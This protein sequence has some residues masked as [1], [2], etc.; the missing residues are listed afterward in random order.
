MNE[1]EHKRIIKRLTSPLDR[2]EWFMHPQTVN[3]Y[4]A[5]T[6]NDIVFPAA[7][8]Q[9]PFFNV[10]G[11]DAVNYGSIGAIIGHEITHGFDDEGSKYDAKGNLKSWWTL[12]DRKRFEA[13]AKKVEKQ[14]NQYSVAGGLKVNGKLTLG[15][16]IADLGGISIAYDAYQ[17]QLERA[18]RTDIDGLTPEQRFFIA[19][20]IFEREHSR[21][22]QAKK[23][24]LTDPHSPGVF[25][26]NGP[27]SNFDHFY[28]AF[29]V[30][31]GDKH[32]RAPK[33]REMV[34]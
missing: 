33:D 16:N 27:V 21:P 10:D 17:L 8:L 4:F 29:G 5:P 3:A 22:E 34:W 9:P 25:R 18:G 15:E 23:Q 28:T 14:Y 12:E 7:I 6:L 32:F 31:K 2:G 13:K 19:L 20:N 26:V 1:F 24:V 30:K 11:D